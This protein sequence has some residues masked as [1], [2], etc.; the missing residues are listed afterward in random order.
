MNTPARS[1]ISAVITCKGRL[2]HAAVSM[3]KLESANLG[4]IVFVDYDCPERSGQWI[5]KHCPSIKVVTVRDRL[6]FNLA[7]ARNLGAAAATRDWILFLDADVISQDL[8]NIDRLLQPNNA[9][10]YICNPLGLKTKKDLSGTVFVRRDE[11]VRVGGYDIFFR[12]WGGEDDDFYWRLARAGC[13]IGS[14]CDSLFSVISHSDEERIRY[15]AIDSKAGAKLLNKV[16]LRA[17]Q[18]LLRS[19]SSKILE[20][21][22]RDR[23]ALRHQIEERLGRV[24][25][26]PSEKR[27]VTL[28]LKISALSQQVGPFQLTEE[29]CV[30]FCINSNGDLA[31]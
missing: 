26:A 9:S 14:Y 30:S 3:P 25:A 6:I 13:T 4:E 31:N 19:A 1:Q 7:E 16:Y 23:Q 11:F 10:V 17:K 2:A 18:H 8:T 12:G 24:L 27:S 21:L 29:C 15:S 5:E 22:D 28:N 20:L